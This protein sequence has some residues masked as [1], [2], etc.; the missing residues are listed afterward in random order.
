MFLCILLLLCLLSLCGSQNAFFAPFSQLLG[1]SLSQTAFTK[2][3]CSGVFG[4]CLPLT[5]NEKVDPQCFS[6]VLRLFTSAAGAGPPAA[7][8][9]P[10]SV[11]AVGAV[12]VA[13]AAAPAAGAAAI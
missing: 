7:V 12:A 6:P 4:S 11:T 10:A 2:K 3:M 13:A 1:P 9:A 5:V 8:A